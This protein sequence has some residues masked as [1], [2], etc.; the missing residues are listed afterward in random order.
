MNRQEYN[1]LLAQ[2]DGILTGFISNTVVPACP[3]SVD[4]YDE[5]KYKLYFFFGIPN[6]GNFNIKIKQYKE[7]KT[8]CNPIV[9]IIRIYVEFETWR[10]VNNLLSEKYSLPSMNNPYGKYDL[11]SMD[12]H[13]QDILIPQFNAFVNFLSYMIING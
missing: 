7:A 9:D 1:R 8:L 10:D 13:V 3:D 6:I 12:Y 2:V 11:I 5:K 4:I